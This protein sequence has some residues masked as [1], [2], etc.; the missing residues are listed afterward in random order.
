M[1]NS[2]LGTTNWNSEERKGKEAKIMLWSPR[3]AG[4]TGCRI[5]RETLKSF[6]AW[7]RE[8]S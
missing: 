6:I 4:R 3:P 2:V 7:Y 8:D 1:G 5:G